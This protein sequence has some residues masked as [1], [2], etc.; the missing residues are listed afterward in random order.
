MS[1]SLSAASVPSEAGENI[2]DKAAVTL[3][4]CDRE[5][6]CFP[7]TIQPFGMLWVLD[8][9]TLEILQ[10]SA[11]VEDFCGLSPREVLGQRLDQAFEDSS[12]AQVQAYLKEREW[13]EP[14]MLRSLFFSSDFCREGTVFEEIAD[15]GASP[16]GRFRGMLHASAEAVILELLP[17]LMV[18]EAVEQAAFLYTDL[19][20]KIGRFRRAESLAE[21]AEQIVEAVA[22][23]TGF[24]RVMVYRFS[25]DH[26]GTVIAESRRSVPETS[27]EDSFLGLR[28]PATDIPMQARS[29]YVQN[30]LRMIPDACYEPVSLIPDRHPVHERPL[31]LS[32]SELRSVSPMHL[33]YLQNM[34]VRASMSVSL[35]VEDKLWGLI[36]CHHSGP[37]QVS[38]EVRKAC[39]FLGQMASLELIRQQTRVEKR[40]LADVRSIQQK[41]KRQ[42]W[43]SRPADAISSVLVQHQQE[44]LTLVRA[45]GGV[46]ALGNQLTLV[47]ETPASDKIKL[48]IDWLVEQRREVCY[49]SSLAQSIP[50]FESEKDCACGLLAISIFLSQS[51]YHVLWLRPEQMRLVD[52]AGDPTK[53]ETITED[54]SLYLTPRQ[55]FERWKQEVHGQSLAW[56]TREIDAAQE[57]RST[58]LLAAL[59]YSQMA[60]K[61]AANKAQVANQAKSQF[62]AKM[63]HELRTPLNAILGFTQLI[64]YHETLSAEQR[65]RLDIINRSGEHLLSLINDVLETSR[66]EAGQLVLNESCFDLHQFIASVKDMLRLRAV[67]KGLLLKVEQDPFLPR[68]V[69]GDESKLR[70]I[71]I[72][73]VGNAIKFT[74][75][76]QVTL[77][78]TCLS[79]EL[80]SS[81]LGEEGSLAAEKQD[82]SERSGM[83]P[84][85]Q[86]QFEVSDTGIGIASENLDAIF[87]P[88]KQTEAGRQAH[89]GTGLGLSI[90]QQNARLMAGDIEVRSQLGEGAT[91]TCRVQ[92]GLGAASDLT[93][94]STERK[95]VALAS[96]QRSP[97]VLVVEDVV[98]NRQLLLSLLT[99]VGFDVR[100]ANNGREA[101]EI[102]RI[103][104]PECIWMD[105]Y[106]PEVDGY[107]ASRQIRAEQEISNSQPPVII[108][109]SASAINHFRRNLVTLGFDDYVSKPFQVNVIFEKMVQHLGVCY[110]YADQEDWMDSDETL[111]TVSSP[112]ALI[113]NKESMAALQSQLSMQSTE[114]QAAFYRAVVGA[115]EQQI[116]RLS[117]ELPGESLTRTVETC[118]KQLRFDVLTQMVEPLSEAFERSK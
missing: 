91:F 84:S 14:L 1:Y 102:W 62:L 86:V 90:S 60:L 37:K 53:K 3:T 92:L 7:G 74:Q 87:E 26:S 35:I 10:V 85:I 5:P 17:E 61:Q 36:A 88:F 79:S 114:W 32:A 110:R 113:T 111:M 115:R 27:G 13:D 69:W 65:D 20:Q 73:L 54:G 118:L 105:L 109:L 55:S 22:A 68:Y 45:S 48:L 59:E 66:I 89:E 46:I 58:L 38:F 104:Q 93:P 16:A 63:S 33:E 76:G 47:G 24:D 103:W 56:T 81:E 99:T 2:T 112:E 19:H 8:E 108:A 77:A 15:E 95:V 30:W 41:I 4:N 57:L 49:T 101:V 67:K 29:L 117:Q 6:I 40:Y 75:Q 21:L 72:N 97:R 64:H 71:I 83:Q 18:E 23:L 106:M 9:T 80:S 82:N 52:W 100:A 96:D 78:V 28:Y 11:N 98:E 44:L 25:K 43:R 116:Y 42:L 31:D 39:M 107:E 51:S 94:S 12:I 70:Q 50:A 34:G